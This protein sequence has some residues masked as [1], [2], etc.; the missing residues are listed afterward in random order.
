MLI[1]GLVM[2]TL[3]TGAII[4]ITNYRKVKRLADEKKMQEMERDWC[5]LQK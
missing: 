4:I 5:I 1:L 2:L 3:V